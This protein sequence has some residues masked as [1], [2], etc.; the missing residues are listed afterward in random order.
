[1]LNVTSDEFISVHEIED[2]SEDEDSDSEEDH[3]TL[4]TADESVCWCEEDETPSHRSGY[5]TIGHSSAIEY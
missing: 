4:S 3:E 1:M 5:V 2:E